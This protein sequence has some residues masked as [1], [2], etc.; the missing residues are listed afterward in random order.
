M[1][2]DNS[3]ADGILMSLEQ[4]RLYLQELYGISIVV[5]KQGTTIVKCPCC[6]KMHDHGPQPE[7]H[8][9][10][11]EV[12]GIG[13]VIGERYFVPNYG[14]TIYE[15]RERDGVNEFIIPE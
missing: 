3:I 9:A 10:L 12:N 4:M 6:S 14:Y 8:V 15:Y 1:R 13:I 7:H 2:N 11:C 5:R